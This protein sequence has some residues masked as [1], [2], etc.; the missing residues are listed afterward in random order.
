MEPTQI[1]MVSMVSTVVVRLSSYVIFICLGSLTGDSTMMAQQMNIGTEFEDILS[2]AKKVTHVG[3]E[4]S[5]SPQSYSKSKTI[6]D[7]SFGKVYLF[8]NPEGKS[9]AVKRSKQ[10]GDDCFQRELKTISKLKHHDN[11]VDFYYHDMIDERVH[12][13]ME[14]CDGSLKDALKKRHRCA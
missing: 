1:N 8:M 11:V 5:F 9:I 14:I 7:G 12:I 6:G 2:K 4:T 3:F 13:Y 10:K